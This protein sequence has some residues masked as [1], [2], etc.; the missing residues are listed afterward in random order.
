[1]PN[2]ITVRDLRNIIGD[3]KIID[4]RDNLSFNRGCIPTAVNIPTNF[5]LV[6]ASSY[7]NKKDTYYIYCETGYTSK[8]ICND[9]MNNGYKVIN[10]IG[11]YQAYKMLGY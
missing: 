6:N 7:L 11:G 2:S 5:L 9:L 1:M 8:R 3:A 4:I 10:V